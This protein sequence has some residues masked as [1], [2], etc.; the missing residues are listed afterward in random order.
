[1]KKC[2]IVMFILSITACGGGSGGSGNTV[3]SGQITNSSVVSS[4]VKSTASS[5]SSV[6]SAINSSISSTIQIASSSVVSSE[7]KST[8]SSSSS[9]SSVKN[10]SSSSNSSVAPSYGVAGKINRNKT[11]W[12]ILTD[13]SQ[14]TGVKTTFLSLTGSGGRFQI[15]CSG[16]V[17]KSYL[18]A[19]NNITDGGTINYR[20]GTNEPVM[21]SW[22]ETS[23]FQVLFPTVSNIPFLQKIYYSNE[24]FMV[25]L[26]YTGSGNSSFST[27]GFPVVI[28]ATRAECGWAESLFP[29][30]NGW[31]LPYPTEAPIDAKESTYIH[32][33][34]FRVLAW[35]GTNSTGNPQ[36]LVRAGDFSGPCEGSYLISPNSFYIRQNGKTVAAVTGNSDK[37]SCKSPEIISLSGDYDASKPLDLEVYSY[38]SSDLDRGTPFT[39]I[40]LN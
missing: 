17:F 8:M 25:Y 1:M 19:T 22:H 16:G 24:M 33:N 26:A 6:S 20:I 12:S 21:E 13:T 32:G 23:N 3:P 28:D 29:V 9:F 15:Q 10:N 27:S 39:V 35:V 4:D 30:D 40:H 38:H 34:A 18:L 31:G 36:I 37:I 11:N 7:A 5:S 14:L 2:L